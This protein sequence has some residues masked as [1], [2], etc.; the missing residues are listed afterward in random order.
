MSPPAALSS[1][2]KAETK[3]P[4]SPVKHS[5]G[6]ESDEY[7]LSG[8]E[9]PDEDDDG[10]EYEDGGEEQGEE[11]LADEDDEDEAWAP[12]GEHTEQ[13]DEE[14]EV[15]TGA[16]VPSVPA[17]AGDSANGNKLK[18]AREEEDVES[19]EANGDEKEEPVAQKRKTE[20]E[21]A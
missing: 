14:E 7:D 6:H 17:A 3:L 15:E 5:D 10:E 8:D 16:E 13:H 20:P 2:G 12:N 1:P 19:S 21:A 18:R 4:S 9:T 11:E